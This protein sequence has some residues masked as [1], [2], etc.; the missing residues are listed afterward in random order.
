VIKTDCYPSYH[1][2]GDSVL[3]D[4]TSSKVP[5]DPEGSNEAIVPIGSPHKAMPDVFAVLIISRDPTGVIH[6]FGFGVD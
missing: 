5:I 3:I 6:T 4:G 1:P 2:C